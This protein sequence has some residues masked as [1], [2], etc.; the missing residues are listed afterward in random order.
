MSSSS[1][2]SFATAFLP[3]GI[4]G[5]SVDVALFPIDTIKTRCQSQQGFVKAGGV[6]GIYSGL[7]AAVSG[8]APSAALFFAT[9]ETVKP[10]ASRVFSDRPVVVQAVSAS[11]GECVASFARV[12]S[13]VVKQRMQAGQY[14]SVKEALRSIMSTEGIRGFYHGHFATVARE[15]PFSFIQF[16]IWERLKKEWA[17]HRGGPTSAWQGALCGAIAG[18]IAAAVTTPLDV[19]KTRHMLGMSRT[20]TLATIRDVYLEGGAPKVFSGVV[21]RTCGIGL[22]GFIFFG[23][24]E[25]C[26][27]ALCKQD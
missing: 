14:N 21:L 17:A 26:S 1:G 8:S 24:Y 22:S 11:I 3:G 9:Y 5:T 18:S 7:S 6:R 25:A 2:P 23:A 13:E 27:H 20:G 12:P 19:A 4:A 15:V 10:F 16:P